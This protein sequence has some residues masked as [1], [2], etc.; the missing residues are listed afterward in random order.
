MPIQPS[1]TVPVQSDETAMRLAGLA[2]FRGLSD[3][4]LERVRGGFRTCELQS[5]Q[6]LFQK[7]DPGNGVYVLLSGQLVG[8]VVSETGRDL[9]LTTLRPTCLFG[10]LSALDN[11][12]RSLTISAPVAS[13][14][15]HMPERRFLDLLEA[16]PRIAINLASELSR[17]NRALNMRV[18]GLVMHDVETRL[19]DLL[20]Q[21]ARHTSDGGPGTTIDPAPTHEVIAAEIGANREAVSR[22]MSRLNRLGVINARRGRIV[23]RDIAALSARISE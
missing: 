18:F 14:L 3:L 2:L 20:L 19:C 1:A 7:G 22:A 15:L 17:R 23:L 9:V 11:L 16:E 21:L 12:P 6:T 10:E 13:Q 4:A 5:G 8:H